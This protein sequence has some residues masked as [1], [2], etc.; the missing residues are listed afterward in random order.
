MFVQQAWKVLLRLVDQ[1][2]ELASSYWS[3]RGMDV[4]KHPSD[5]Q[6][7]DIFDSLVKGKTLLELDKSLMILLYVFSH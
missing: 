1:K 2:L 6:G 5:W 3:L 7:E 4:Y